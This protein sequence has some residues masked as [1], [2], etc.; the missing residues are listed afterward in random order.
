MTADEGPEPKDHAPKHWTV[1]GFGN[2]YLLLA[3]AAL[4]WSGNHIVGRAMGGHVPPLTVST[5]RWLFPCVVLWAIAHRRMWLSAPAS[6]L[7][8]TCRSTSSFSFT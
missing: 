6:S 4:F 5:L 1:R 3:V 2:P 7:A 8:S